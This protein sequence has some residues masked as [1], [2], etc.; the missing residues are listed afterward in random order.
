MI[1]ARV[2]PQPEEAMKIQYRLSRLSAGERAFYEM[3]LMEEMDNQHWFFILCAPDTGKE[4][5]ISLQ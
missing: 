4:L 2:G 5:I 3:V 1:M